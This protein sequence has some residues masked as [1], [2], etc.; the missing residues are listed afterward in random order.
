M[1]TIMIGKS[2]MLLPAIHRTNRLRGS[3]FHGPRAMDQPIY[4][5]ILN[6]I[7]SLTSGILLVTIHLHEVIYTR[8][9]KSCL[10]NMLKRPNA[11][12]H[13]NN[14]V[15]ANMTVTFITRLASAV[16]TDSCNH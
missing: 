2:D 16:P 8:I 15:L 5:K 4:N 13:L 1:P 12:H 3:C 9:I 11:I 6:F 14:C 10:L 7:V